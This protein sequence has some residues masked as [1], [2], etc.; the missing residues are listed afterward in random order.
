MKKLSWQ[1]K[2]RLAKLNRVLAENPGAHWAWLQRLEA[3]GNLL[4]FGWLELLDRLMVRGVVSRQ[5]VLDALVDESFDDEGRY[6]IGAVEDN[7][8]GTFAFSVRDGKVVVAVF[9]HLP[10]ALNFTWSLVD[11]ARGPAASQATEA[12]ISPAIP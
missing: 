6:S 4:Y 1:A 2:R 11:A 3:E 12:N 9:D 7:D 5:A 8:K 10:E